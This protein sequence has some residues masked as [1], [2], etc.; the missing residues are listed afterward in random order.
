MQCEAVNRSIDTLEED[1]ATKTGG[2]L[3]TQKD[4][5]NGRDTLFLS[6]D[7]KINAFK[8]ERSGGGWRKMSRGN[9]GSLKN[10]CLPAAL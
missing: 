6:E 10:S 4:K 3:R 1:L 2:L 9:S 7:K 5:V 8:R